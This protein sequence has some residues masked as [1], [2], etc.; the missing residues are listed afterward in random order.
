MTLRGVGLVE[1]YKR[2][3]IEIGKCIKSYQNPRFEPQILI[4]LFKVVYNYYKGNVCESMDDVMLTAYSFWRKAQFPFH[5]PNLKQPHLLRVISIESHSI[6]FSDIWEVVVVV[7]F[8]YYFMEQI[9][10]Q[11]QCPSNLWLCVRILFVHVVVLS[12]LSFPFFAVSALFHHSVRWNWQGSVLVLGLGSQTQQFLFFILS[13]FHSLP[14][15]HPCEKRVVRK[16]FGFMVRLDETVSSFP[17]S[18][19]PFL[20]YLKH[21]LL[22][23]VILFPFKQ[24]QDTL[25]DSV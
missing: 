17:S 24:D 16:V 8:G 10:M 12:L 7:L 15:S 5:F 3:G 6:L 2:K 22:S 20:S 11:S 23:W 4:I 25:I 9:Q 18:T 13:S 1:G 14:L 19:F 21:Y